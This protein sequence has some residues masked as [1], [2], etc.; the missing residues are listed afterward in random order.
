[1]ISCPRKMKPIFLHIAIMEKA[2]MI[3]SCRIFLSIPS[4]LDF[5]KPPVENEDYGQ[6]IRNDLEK[7][8][9]GILGELLEV[10]F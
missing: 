3:I 2:M 6:H 10:Y 7:K 9:R 1:M 5:K 4:K 8:C